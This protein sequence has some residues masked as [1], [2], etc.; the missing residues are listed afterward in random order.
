M[1]QIIKLELPDT[2]L[3][4]AQEIAF[5]SGRD[6]KDLLTEWIREAIEDDIPLE[7]LNDE[8][9]LRVASHQMDADQQAELSELFVLKRDNRLD[10]IRR[11]RFEY[12]MEIYRRGMTRKLRALRIA[13]E[14]DL[15]PPL[16]PP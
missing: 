10:N 13:H 14:R 11:V 12:L 6:L 3:E 1:G 2:L 8:H 7:S 15:R 16:A 5:L 9:L 4:Q